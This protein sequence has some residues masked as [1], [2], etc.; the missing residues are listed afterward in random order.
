MNPLPLSPRGSHNRTARVQHA[1]DRRDR[2]RCRHVR[3]RGRAHPPGR[4]VRPAQ[5]AD[6]P[7]PHAVAAVCHHVESQQPRCR[8]PRP[9]DAR[10]HQVAQQPRAP[11]HTQRAP[12]HLPCTDLTQLRPRLVRALVHVLAH[13]RQ[14]EPL[15]SLCRGAGRP[16]PDLVQHPD[17]RSERMFPRLAL[18]HERTAAAARRHL[19]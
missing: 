7:A 16:L 13:T 11:R 19:R 2:V 9:L 5:R 18:A 3:H 10:I 14:I 1:L 17:L 8:T 12:G 4:D 6:Q 15:W